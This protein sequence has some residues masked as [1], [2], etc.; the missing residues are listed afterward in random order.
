VVSGEQ[1]NVTSETSVLGLWAELCTIFSE[2]LH[3][4][5]VYAA[6]NQVM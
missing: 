1:I 3:C 2:D 4:M 5:T 6:G